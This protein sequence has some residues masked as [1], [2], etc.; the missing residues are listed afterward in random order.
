MMSCVTV[1][2]VTEWLHDHITQEKDVEGSGI[3][4]VKS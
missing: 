4:D 3:D 2:Q 1:T